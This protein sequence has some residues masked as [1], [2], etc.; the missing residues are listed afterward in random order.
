MLVQGFNISDSIW[1]GLRHCQRE[2]IKVAL[3]YIKKPVSRKS[4]LI[5]LPTG[6]GKTGVIATLAHVS[7]KSR[8]LVLCHRKAVRD[9]YIV[10]KHRQ[11]FDEIRR[12]CFICNG[13]DRAS[14]YIFT[15]STYTD[16]SGQSKSV[17]QNLLSSSL[18]HL[19]VSIRINLY[20]DIIEDR[21]IPL[22]T[23]AAD[24]YENDKLIVRYA[25][26]KDVCDKIIHADTV[27]ESIFKHFP[28]EKDE[29]LTF[30]LKGSNRDKLWKFFGI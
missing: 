10:E 6:S 8:V 16:P 2:S 14:S 24:Y 22:A 3:R 11:N 23:M 28:L 30:Q 7:K 18:L 13:L 29:K 1:A 26:I 25:S 4:S 12:L 15:E 27:T 5:S 9:Q 19:A 20:Q 21:P 17:L